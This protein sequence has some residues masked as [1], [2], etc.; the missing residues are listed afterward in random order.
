[1]DRCEGD[2]CDNADA[3]EVEEAS[4]ANPG[5]TQTLEHWGYSTGEGEHCTIYFRLLKYNN[6]EA[7]T[8]A[9]DVSKA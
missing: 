3:D 2:D 9:S 5:L 7:N 6:R 8:N 4:Q 1:M